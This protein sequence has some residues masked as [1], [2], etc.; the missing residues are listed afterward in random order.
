MRIKGR[1]KFG[2]KGEWAYTV[3]AE[4]YMMRQKPHSSDVS[5]SIYNKKRIS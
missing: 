1:K 3:D 2:A 5:C 4:L